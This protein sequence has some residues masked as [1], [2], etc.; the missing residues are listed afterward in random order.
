MF[1][2]FK[3]RSQYAFSLSI[4]LLSINFTALNIFVSLCK[5][6]YAAPKLPS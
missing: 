5:H 6:T 2:S 3:K 4:A 1:I